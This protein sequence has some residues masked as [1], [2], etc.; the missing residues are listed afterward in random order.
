MIGS[1]I[2]RR[3]K[4]LEKNGISHDRYMELVYFCKQY[5]EKKEKLESMALIQGMKYSSMPKTNNVESSAERMAIKRVELKRDIEAIEKTAEEVAPAIK[6]SL[7]LNVT[8]GI[9]YTYFNLPCGKNYFYRC[10]RNFFN[11]L[12]EKV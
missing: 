9:T 12:A 3:S 1:G 11:K 4:R 2:L 10:R 8:Q 6:D 7:L 5:K